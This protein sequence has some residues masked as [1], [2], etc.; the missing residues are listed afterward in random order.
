MID[1]FGSPE[2]R[3]RFGCLTAGFIGFLQQNAEFFQRLHADIIFLQRRLGAGQIGF[4]G[5]QRIPFFFQIVLLFPEFF[6]GGGC[7]QQHA[8]GCGCLAFGVGESF[9]GLLETAVTHQKATQ[10]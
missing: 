7:L 2:I 9:I 4:R 1:C 3:R 5:F 10:F 6:Q 8:L